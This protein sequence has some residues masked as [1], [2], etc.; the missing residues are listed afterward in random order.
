MIL[1]KQTSTPCQHGKWCC[2]VEPDCT[3]TRVN[4]DADMR[5]K[6]ESTG[7]LE[8]FAWSG[9]GAMVTSIFAMMAVFIKI[10]SDDKGMPTADA[11]ALVSMAA[12]H[13][14]QTGDSLGFTADHD[15]R[16]GRRTGVSCNM[17]RL[18]CL[19]WFALLVC[20]SCDCGVRLG[21][22]LWWGRAVTEA[23]VQISKC[24]PSRN[25]L[26][27]QLEFHKLCSRKSPSLRLSRDGD[28]NRGWLNPTG[29]IKTALPSAS[30][31]FV[32]LV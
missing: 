17:Q 15:R 20:A 3:A 22:R 11:E 2:R 10:I 30:H 27:I 32:Y 8:F 25:S 31:L 28:K 5:R 9:S 4:G 7:Y 14:K 18:W 29:P 26:W 23:L 12:R 16:Q 1:S 19:A 21:F 6:A 24:S 13:A